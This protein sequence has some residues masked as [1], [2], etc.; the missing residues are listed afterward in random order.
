LANAYNKTGHSAEAIQSARQALDLAIE[1][2]DDQLAKSLRDALE[3]YELDG[4]ASR[5]Q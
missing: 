2:H 4:A 3:R 1:Q 5:P